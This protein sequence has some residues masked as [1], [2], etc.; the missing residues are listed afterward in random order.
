MRALHVVGVDLQP[1][2]GVDSCRIR[3]QDVVVLL[4]RLGF[5][6]VRRDY[7]LAEESALGFTGSQPVENL[8]GTAI[9]SAVMHRDVERHLVVAGAKVYSRKPDFGMRSGQ[10]NRQRNPCR[11]SAA[12]PP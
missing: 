8:S 2:L 3:K 12:L 7:D 6:G 10:V 5:L 4:E 11:D 9:A 1:G